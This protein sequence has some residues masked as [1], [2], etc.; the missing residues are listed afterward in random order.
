MVEIGCCLVCQREV[1]G[2]ECF[3]SCFMRRS[4]CSSSLALPFRKENRRMACCR[5]NT[6]VNYLAGS[7]PNAGSLGQGFAWIFWGRA[8]PRG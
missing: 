3:L 2:V 8:V 4:V 1:F 7:D 6:R 5:P